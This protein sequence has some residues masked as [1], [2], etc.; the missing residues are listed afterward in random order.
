MI[1][2]EAQR[3]RFAGAATKD[4]MSGARPLPPIGKLIVKQEPI[5][6]AREQI[7]QLEAEKEARRLA[8]RAKRAK[9]S[10]SNKPITKSVRP[11]LDEAQ[12]P[13]RSPLIA[14][15]SGP[16][17]VRKTVIVEKRRLPTAPKEGK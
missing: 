16:R 15:Q 6:E 4:V 5:D 11:L 8:R 2:P 17:G 1:Y 3:G 12:S 13:S 9:K 7:I 10:K 14:I